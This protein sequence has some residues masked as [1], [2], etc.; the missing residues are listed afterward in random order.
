MALLLCDSFERYADF[1]DFKAVHGS[2]SQ[3]GT[4]TFP[5]DGRFGGGEKVFQAGQNFISN[6]RGFGSIA[7]NNVFFLHFAV[8]PDITDDQP[9]DSWTMASARE[10]GDNK[11]H[12]NINRRGPDTIELRRGGVLLES[13]TVVGVLQNDSWHWIEA[14][15]KIHDSTGSWQVKVDGVE[16]LN[17]TGDTRNGGVT[18]DFDE[19]R[20]TGLNK[21]NSIQFDD[22]VVWDDTG[23][24]LNDF[25]ATELRVEILRPDSAGA[26]AQFTPIGLAANW[27]N[28]DKADVPTVLGSNYNESNTVTNKDTVNMDAGGLSGDPLGVRLMIAALKEG[29]GARS[30]KT[31]LRSGAGT[32]VDGAEFALGTGLEFHATAHDL[33]PG[34][35]AWDNTYRS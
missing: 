30:V 17:G 7:E 2:G 23:T 26:S 31:V 10:A 16:V 21:A 18:G 9:S 33:E 11:D 1:D 27:Q 29:A 19:L 35:A 8:K 20:L 24:T 12:I 5:A 34:G 4:W 13:A 14:K 28:L 22:L 25:P 32:E 15:L 6:F 3:S